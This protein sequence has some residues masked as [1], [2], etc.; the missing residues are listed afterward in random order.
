MQ[1]LHLRSSGN[2]GVPASAHGKRNAFTLIELLV[3]IA[4]IAILAAILFPVFAQAREKARMASCLSNV[5]QISLALVEYTQD[6]DEMNLINGGTASWYWYELLQPYVKDPPQGYGVGS[7]W[8]CPDDNAN[9]TT[10]GSLGGFPHQQTTDESGT[11]LTGVHPTY[12]YGYTANNY[13]YSD[14]V[15]GALLQGIP[16]S[17]V[18]D[19]SGTVFIGEGGNGAYS[20]QDRDQVTKTTPTGGP[21]NVPPSNY[22]AWL[23]TPLATNTPQSLGGKQGYFIARHNGGLNLGFYDGHAKWMPMTSFLSMDST[24]TYFKYLT[25]TAD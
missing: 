5:K 17:T 22:A 9:G 3:V 21:A 24:N 25:K 19:A 20:S 16:M 8:D 23:T 1:R 13:Y 12:Y 10:Y 18:D 4:I 6:Y 15:H 2:S 7:V 14:K 11:A